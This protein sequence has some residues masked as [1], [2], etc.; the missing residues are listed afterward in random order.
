MESSLNS[1]EVFQPDGDI[2]L[3]QLKIEEN[4]EQTDKK[5]FKSDGHA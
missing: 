1:F 2:S 3:S 4:N 5:E